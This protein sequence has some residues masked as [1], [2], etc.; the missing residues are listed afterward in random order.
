MNSICTRNENKD[1]CRYGNYCSFPYCDED[2]IEP[3]WVCL[4]CAKN[5]NARMPEGHCATFHVGLCGIC[6]NEVSVTEPRDFGITR[7]R[8]RIKESK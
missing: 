6:G 3:T 4:Q 5:R 8:L 7:Y 1:I 2:Y